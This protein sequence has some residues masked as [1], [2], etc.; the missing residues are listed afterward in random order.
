MKTLFTGSNGSLGRAYLRLYP[1]TIPMPIRYGSG[2]QFNALVTGASPKGTWAR[3]LSMPVEG[4]LE[5]GSKGLDVGDRI[6][7]ELTSV[8]V[9]RGYIDFMRVG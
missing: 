3:L 7:V 8:S 1:D 4:R 9:E 6:R 2:E 5:R